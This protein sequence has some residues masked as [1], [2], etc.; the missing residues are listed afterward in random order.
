M[1]GIFGTV[2]D[3]TVIGVRIQRI[4]PR[5]WV[6]IGNKMTLTW[7]GTV[8]RRTDRCRHASFGAVVEPVII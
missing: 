1:I 3:A 2:V 6:C 5:G 8:A 7:I 4:G